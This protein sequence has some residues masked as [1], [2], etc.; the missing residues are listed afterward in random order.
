[1]SEVQRI[2]DATCADLEVRTS[3]SSQR[4]P[5]DVRST[6]LDYWTDQPRRQLPCEC[7]S[8]LRQIHL[9]KRLDSYVYTAS[10]SSPTPPAYL[11]SRY[12]VRI[13]SNPLPS[14]G[15][16]VRPLHQTGLG[17]PPQHVTL[18]LLMSDLVL[19]DLRNGMLSCRA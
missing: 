12:F 18:R 11:Y 14:T 5:S 6:P 3:S 10:W 16:V 2:R 9:L 4:H 8:G 17:E 7:P 15:V 13:E 19:Y 1:M